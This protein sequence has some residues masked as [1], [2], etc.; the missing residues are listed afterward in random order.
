MRIAFIGH[1]YH[2]KTG[3]SRFWVDLLRQLGTVEQMFGDPD[4]H[5]LRGWGVEF[6]ENR[7]DA[8]VIWQLHEAFQLLSGRHP[9]VVFVPMYDAMLWAG[10]FYWKPAFRSAKIACFS[11]ALRREVMRRGAVHAGF[12]YFPDPSSCAPVEDFSSLRGFFWYRRKEITPA[13]V[14][15]L[16]GDAEFERF[17]VHDAPDPGHEAESDWTAPRTI[18]RL[19]RTV[20]SEDGGDYAAAVCNSNV[21]FAPRPCEG[22]GMSVLEAMAAGRCVVAPHAPTMNEYISHGTNGLLYVPGRPSHLDFRA[23][24]DIGARARESVE[25]GYDRWRTAIPALLD[26]VATPT[27]ALAGRRPPVAVR[28]SYAAAPRSGRDGRP[29]VSVVTV[30]RN[31]AAVLPGTMASVLS[32][33][34]CSFEYVVLDGESSDGSLEIIR[35]HAGQLATWRSAPDNGPYDAMNAAPEVAR[36]EF[37]LFMNAGDSFASDDALQRMFARVPEDAEVVYGHHIYRR[38]DGSEELSRAADFE[39]TW[40]RLQRGQLWFDWLG[41]IPGHQATAVRRD[42]LARLRFDTNY[43]I[44]ADHDLLFRARAQGARFFN[45]DEVVAIY[46]AGGLSSRQQEVCWKEWAKIA[47]S[48]G[49]AQA[50]DV[51][52]AHF[53]AVNAAPASRRMDKAGRMAMRTIASLDRYSPLMARI[54]EQIARNPRARALVRRLLSGAPT[55]PPQSGAVAAE[56]RRADTPG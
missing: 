34:G 38:D 12:Q 3:S 45:S 9:N 11:W 44:A 2:Q 49:D 54:A 15:D 40:S 46:V 33:A 10:D 51:F 16:C 29:L 22:I 53:E 21:Y 5:A 26:F 1:S 13:V 25:R 48:H 56:P 23:A 52:Y 18:L 24:R 19:D 30:C 37:V 35:H 27:A 7:Y 28:N 14:F 36:G 17:T 43:R 32:Q 6:D 8:I 4:G 20:W 50:A 31:A 47:R 55:R 39:M 42:L 41:G